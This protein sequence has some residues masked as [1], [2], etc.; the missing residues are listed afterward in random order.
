MSEPAALRRRD[1]ETRAETRWTPAAPGETKAILLIQRQDLWQEQWMR[2]RRLKPPSWFK[3][4]S[5]VALANGKTGIDRGPAFA[6][7]VKEF[8]AGHDYIAVVEQP[9]RHQSAF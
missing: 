8:V 2:F 9:V 6:I 3:H 7:I 5:V 1:E 4:A